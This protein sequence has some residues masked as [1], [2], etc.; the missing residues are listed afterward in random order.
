MVLFGIIR[1]DQTPNCGVLPTIG[2]QD[3]AAAYTIV[4]F[5]SLVTNMEV[6]SVP[7]LT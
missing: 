7:E 3:K 6:A 4:M 2:L 1:A 5:M